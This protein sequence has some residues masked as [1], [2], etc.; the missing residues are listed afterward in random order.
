MLVLNGRFFKAATSDTK[1]TSRYNAI[2]QKQEVCQQ[3]NKLI[4][5][6]FLKKC[7]TV[8]FKMFFFKETETFLFVEAEKCVRRERRQ[9]TLVEI[10]STQTD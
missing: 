2:P 4:N 9:M 1:K 3:I 10:D 6:I 5:A 7:F 8:D